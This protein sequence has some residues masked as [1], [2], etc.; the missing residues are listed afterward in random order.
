MSVNVLGAGDLGGEQW[1]RCLQCG[2][3]NRMRM[4]LTWAVVMPDDAARVDRLV[5]RVTA[6]SLLSENAR[7]STTSAL[8]FES[9]GLTDLDS[10]SSEST[11]SRGRSRSRSR[12]PPLPVMRRSEA[13]P[14]Q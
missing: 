10:S 8:R 9:R 4:D 14:P 5:P 3:V 7:A 2:H 11:G 12:S 6:A 13:R 1:V